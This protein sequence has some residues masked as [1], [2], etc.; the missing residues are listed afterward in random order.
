M[1]SKFVGN[2]GLDRKQA[3][4]SRIHPQTSQG[5]AIGHAPL[6]LLPCLAIAESKMNRYVHSNIV[7]HS[8]KN[9]SVFKVTKYIPDEVF[10]DS[11]TVQQILVL[12]Y[13]KLIHYQKDI[14][15][16]CVFK[17]VEVEVL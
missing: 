3:C 7:T 16:L 8:S 17:N 11:L 15:R 10:T 9:I 1:P 2:K 13:R 4:L 12:N 14:F 5:A 6:L